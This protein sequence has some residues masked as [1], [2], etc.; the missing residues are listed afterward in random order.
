[1]HFA[2]GAFPGTSM[3]MWVS[4]RI[5]I[6]MMNLVLFAR[7]WVSYTLQLSLIIVQTSVNWIEL[8]IER[9]FL[10]SRNNK[11]LTLVDRWFSYIGSMPGTGYPSSSSFCTCTYDIRYSIALANHRY[12]LVHTF[13]LQCYGA[14]LRM[15]MRITCIFKLVCMCVPYVTF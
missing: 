2:I 14:I 1:M 11:L 10:V 13:T 8:R 6:F 15:H 5:R 4:A 9:K 3:L 12:L 7:E